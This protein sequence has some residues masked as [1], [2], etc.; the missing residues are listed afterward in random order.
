MCICLGAFIGLI[1]VPYKMWEFSQRSDE[2]TELLQ[3]GTPVTLSL[4]RDPDERFFLNSGYRYFV[5][6]KGVVGYS[7]REKPTKDL[8]SLT[9]YQETLDEGLPRA[10]EVP[11][12]PSFDTIYYALYGESRRRSLVNLIAIVCV[13][14]LA[15]YI[16]VR[17]FYFIKGKK[18]P[19]MRRRRRSR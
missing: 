19:R 8:E 12:D 18:M 4:I 2:T 3:N 7:H 6:Y 16:A 17:G 5:E 11:S 10:I 15:V 13:W 1:I 14:L 9:F